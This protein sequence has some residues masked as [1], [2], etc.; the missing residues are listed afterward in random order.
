[1]NFIGWINDGKIVGVTDLNG[2]YGDDGK[3]YCAECFYYG[4][5]S[6]NCQNAGVTEGSVPVKW[7]AENKKW[8]LVG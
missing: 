6:V 8:A 2:C 1:M 3:C 7:D 4:A 5:D